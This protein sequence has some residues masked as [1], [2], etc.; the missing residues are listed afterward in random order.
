MQF[1]VVNPI[2]QTALFAVVF[3]LTLVFVKVNR[4]AGFSKEITIQLKG[5]SILAIVLGHI[6]YFL[7]SDPQFLYPF[8]IISGVGVNLF[9]FLSGFG[10]TLSSQNKLLNPLAFY[11]KRL[12]KL[13]LPIWIIITVFLILDFFLLHRSYSLIE[14][15]KNYLGLFITANPAFSLDSPLWYFTLIVFYYLIFP[16]VFFKKAPWVSPILIFLISLIV[17]RLPL[18]VSQDNLTLFTLHLWAFPL[19]I[20]SA[21]LMNRFQFSV[22]PSLRLLLLIVCLIFFGYTA[23]YS[24]VGQGPN[25]EQALSLITMFCLIGIFLLS[26]LNF[27]LFSLFGIYAYEIYLL[28]WPILS[29]YNL[30]LGLPPFLV[31]ILNLSLILFLGYTLQKIIS[32]QR[33]FI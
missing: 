1:L 29:R 27:K 4:A 31:V 8:S 22:K 21:F 3:F 23:V 19:G 11:K 30:F 5:V 6:G 9:L 33:I 13:Y 15:M 16:W 7:S 24:G 12:P 32:S 28:H 17:I 14:T 2:L 18:P 20:T 25:I 26:G 10:L